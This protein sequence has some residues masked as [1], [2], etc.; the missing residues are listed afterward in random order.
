M[1][2]DGPSPLFTVVAK[3]LVPSASIQNPTRIAIENCKKASFC[4]QWSENTSTAALHSPNPLI[5]SAQPQ[6]D[7]E[8]TTY[9]NLLQKM[10]K[11][12]ISFIFIAF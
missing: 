6:T 12:P 8:C 9:L 7:V 2:K 11:E 4:Q 5:N 3:I 1:C 10:S